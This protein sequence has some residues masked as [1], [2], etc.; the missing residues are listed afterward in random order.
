MSLAIGL[1]VRDT[2]LR[3]QQERA[4]MTKATL[5][6]ITIKKSEQSPLYRIAQERAR[7]SWSMPTGPKNPTGGKSEDLKWLLG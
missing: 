7:N 1:W 5:N 2:A 6:Q 4:N 3:L